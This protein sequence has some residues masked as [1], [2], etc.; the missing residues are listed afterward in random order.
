MCARKNKKPKR[1]CLGI[2]SWLILELAVVVFDDGGFVDVEWEFVTLRKSGEGSAELLSVNAD[3]AAAGGFG[4]HGF[5]DDLQRA[6][7]FEGDDVADLTKAG[8]DV[9]LLAVDKDVSMVDELTGAG[10]GAGES[11]TIDEVVEPGLKDPEEGETGDGG[12]LLSKDEETTELTLVDAIEVPEFLLLKELDSVFGG[13]PL[14]ILAVL[15]GAIRPLLQF[16]ARLES[17]EVK[18]AGLFP[19][20]FGVPRHFL[21][22]FFEF[23]KVRCLFHLPGCRK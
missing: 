22:P 10:T 13:F 8:S 21:S 12:V 9:A 15:A 3:I 18:V 5:P 2:Q 14:A 20:A 23:T 4:L 6:L 11:H 17:R 1:Q 16:V 19:R 7:L